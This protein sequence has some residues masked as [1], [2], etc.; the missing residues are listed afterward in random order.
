MSNVI[1]FHPPKDREV[2]AL[3][4][5]LQVMMPWMDWEDPVQSF[6]SQP[7]KECCPLCR[8]E[9]QVPKRGGHNGS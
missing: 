3:R 1:A 7:E 6:L 2:E 4:K 9:G 5:A 8:G